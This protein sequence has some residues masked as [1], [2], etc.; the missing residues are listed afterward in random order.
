MF[1]SS[2]YAKSVTNESQRSPDRS[3]LTTNPNS[4]Y[5]QPKNFNK[6][7][8]KYL[9]LGKIGGNNLLIFSYSQRYQKN[10]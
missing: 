4:V 10:I 8:K 5:F 1:G 9:V 3:V 6:F 2:A 7:Y